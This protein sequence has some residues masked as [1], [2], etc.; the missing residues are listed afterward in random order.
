MG[1]FAIERA[2]T[3]FRKFL[4]QKGAFRNCVPEHFFP[5]IG[6]TNTA[7]LL[8]NLVNSLSSGTFSKEKK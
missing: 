4:S 5:G 7:P 1:I 2:G 3:P 6:I 8:V